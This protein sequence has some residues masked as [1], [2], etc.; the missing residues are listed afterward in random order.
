MPRLPVLLGLLLLAGAGN[1]LRPAGEAV[2]RKPAGV[3]TGSVRVNSGGSWRFLPGKE[4]ERAGLGGRKGW[5]RWAGLVADQR[6]CRA[7]Q[8]RP[9]PLA[10]C[11]RPLTM[12]DHHGPCAAARR[13]C[14]LGPLPGQ[15]LRA[16]QLWP[17]GGPHQRRLQRRAAGLRR[18]P[19]AGVLGRGRT[20]QRAAQRGAAGSMSAGNTKAARLPPVARR[21][22]PQGTC[23]PWHVVCRASPSPCA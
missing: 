17:A 7:A 18:W 23:L 16:Q 12:G 6:G 14:R 13:R 1:A 4:G 8:G 5:R 19:G 20:V 3:A 22:Q 15:R 2:Q 11:L 21:A 10:R 9:L